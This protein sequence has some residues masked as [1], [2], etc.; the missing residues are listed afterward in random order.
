MNQ[1]TRISQTDAA[2]EQIKEYLLTGKIQVGEKLPTE[3]MF[4]QVLKVGRST[5][6]EA[7]RVLQVMGYVKMLPGRGAFLA[8]K[9]LDNA[10]PGIV[11]W[12]DSHKV[13]SQDVVEVR[14]ALETLSIRLAVKRALPQDLRDI[15]NCRQRYE[16]AL[17]K[18]E[19]GKLGQF[20]EAFHQAIAVS[21][22]ND[23]LIDLNKS[24]SLAFFEYRR[25]SFLIKEHAANAVIP[26]RD[27]TAALFARDGDLAQLLMIRHLERILADRET[28][29]KNYESLVA[30]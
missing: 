3:K 13:Q 17:A 21:A 23:L 29:I 4:C 24:V 12:F 10:S 5:V 27:I 25:N 22:K 9:Q 2:V 20:D 15:D 26:H 7:L 6:R 14:M 28:S 1:V 30:G 16:D 18:E 11:S 19:Y 8:A